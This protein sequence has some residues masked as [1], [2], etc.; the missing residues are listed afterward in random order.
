MGKHSDGCRT[1][2]AEGECRWSAPAVARANQQLVGVRAGRKRCEVWYGGRRRVADGGALKVRGRRSGSDRGQGVVTV[3]EDGSVDHRPG[4][5]RGC[6]GGKACPQP[7]GGRCVVRTSTRSCPPGGCCK[8]PPR[9]P[10]TRS[11]SRGVGEETH[12]RRPLLANALGAEDE[13][14]GTELALPG[15][16]LASRRPKIQQQPLPIG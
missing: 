8:R 13:K 6:C 3:D 7:S 2:S 9:G 11:S 1:R 4:S 16:R 10:S 12:A 15:L 5:S 14:S